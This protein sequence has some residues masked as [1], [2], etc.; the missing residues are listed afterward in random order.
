MRPS[1]ERPRAIPSFLEGF[2]EFPCIRCC[3][4]HL[5]PHK[6]Q[7]V[8]TQWA[9]D[10]TINTIGCR[11]HNGPYANWLRHESPVARYRTTLCP[12]WKQCLQAPSCTKEGH[13][14]Q[15][16][17][18]KAWGQLHL[19]VRATNLLAVNTRPA[20]NAELDLLSSPRARCGAAKEKERR[21]H[22]EFSTATPNPVAFSIV[23]NF[24]K[25]QGQL[26]A[27][28]CL[29]QW[30]NCLLPALQFWNAIVLCQAA[31]QEATPACIQILDQVA[32]LVRGSLAAVRRGSPHTHF[33][34]R[35]LSSWSEQVA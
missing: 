6:F 16:R 2:C 15:R 12:S 29:L 20:R 3:W 17:R 11:R 33:T 7:D 30:S 22:L 18:S 4:Q 27:F 34:I 26:Q 5:Q 35:P 28:C 10:R 1:E 9:A 25:N 32:R 21:A 19:F 14:L 23:G 13:T 31:V 8:S 24:F